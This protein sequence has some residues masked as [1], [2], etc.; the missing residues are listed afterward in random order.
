MNKLRSVS[1]RCLNAEKK[2]VLCVWLCCFLRVGRVIEL[3]A[4]RSLSEVGFETN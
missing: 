1:Y 3:L 2:F 4:I